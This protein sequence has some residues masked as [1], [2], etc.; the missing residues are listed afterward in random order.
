MLVLSLQD[1]SQTGGFA[2]RTPSRS[3]E[4]IAQGLL[5]K[6]DGMTE[7]LLMRLVGLSMDQGHSG[8][9]LTGR[10]A[11]RRLALRTPS[12]SVVLL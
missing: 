1:A 6:C 8:P 10:F 9:F 12:R 7:G 5:T 4:M 2:L 11:D 3:E